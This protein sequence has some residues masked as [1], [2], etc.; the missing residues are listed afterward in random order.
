MTCPEQRLIEAYLDGELS[1]EERKVFAKHLDHCST[2]RTTLAEHKR[3]AQWADDVIDESLP[4]VSDADMDHIDVGRAWTHFQAALQE[5]A[6]V[7]HPD[8]SVDEPKSVSHTSVSAPPTVLTPPKR[9][10]S[11]MA[12]TYQKWIAGTAAAVVVIGS[13][14]MPQVQA[15]ATD[16]LSMFRVEKFEMITLTEDDINEV[17]K[18]MN[19]HEAGEIDLEG[20]GTFTKHEGGQAPRSFENIELAQKEG[21][22]PSPT[23]A[24]FK[25]ETLDIQPEFTIELKLDI[26][27]TNSMLKTLGA[28]VLFDE[29]LH[30]QPFTVTFPHMTETRY[31]STERSDLRFSYSV[32]KTPHL[33][34]PAGVDIGQLRQ[35]V[36]QLP[37]IPPQVS[38]QLAR[39]EDW[40]STVPLP[41]VEG[42]NEMEKISVNG[43]DGLFI[44]EGDRDATL[45]WQKDSKLHHAHIDGGGFVREDM[46]KYLT[47]LAKT[48]N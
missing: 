45:I 2:C 31:S 33:E 10:W 15:A 48:Y 25:A 39:I 32:L 44:Y 30:N 22:Q 36:L 47:E 40:Q 8:N 35:T 28:T 1:R 27:K 41:Y 21:F 14:S 5:R 6:A 11:T 23:P 42:N 12:K 26:N 18:W 37:F 29:K 7:Q 4:H 24:G 20:L 34:A 16:L 17:S 43:T 9:R 19:S 13:L 38:E 46:K 3:L